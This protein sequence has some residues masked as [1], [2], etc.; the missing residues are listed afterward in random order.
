MISNTSCDHAF[1]YLWARVLWIVDSNWEN[2]TDF[3]VIGINLFTN[4]IFLTLQNNKV[5]SKK[6]THNFFMKKKHSSNADPSMISEK[7]PPRSPYE[8][9]GLLWDPICSAKLDIEKWWRQWQPSL[10]TWHLQSTDH[11]E[12]KTGH[13]FYNNNTAMPNRLE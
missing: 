7:K 12:Y 11:I 4:L 5:W 13:V 8:Q 9:L 10:Y 3:L 2:R 1:R 6:I